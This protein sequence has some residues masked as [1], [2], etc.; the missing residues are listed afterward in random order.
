[1]SGKMTSSSGDIEQGLKE[2][3]DTQVL[4]EAETEPVSET[5]RNSQPEMTGQR[6]TEKGLPETKL[7]SELQTE[8]GVTD[9]GEGRAD[10]SPYVFL[11]VAAGMGIVLLGAAFY[12]LVNQKRKRKRREWKVRK[13]QAQKNERDSIEWQEQDMEPFHTHGLQEIPRTERDEKRPH[14]IYV[15]KVHDIGKRS[16]QQDS[17]GISECSQIDQKGVFAIV[18]DGMGGLANG[19]EISAMVTLSMM[20][21]FDSQTMQ[22][23][24]QQE[25]LQMLNSANDEVN[26]VLGT[27]GKGKSGSTVVAVLVQKD[28]LYWIAVG[29]SHIYL[30]RNGALMQVNREHVYG[31][32][33][34]EQAGRGEISFSAAASDPQRKALTSFIGIGKLKKIDRNIRPLKLLEG[35]RVLLMSDGVFGTLSDGEIAEAMHA[36]AEMSGEILDRMI[37]SKNL[38]NQDNYTA[39]ILEYM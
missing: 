4:S 6:E 26:Q 32:E 3:R 8:T 20:S 7:E 13:E 38:A 15:G 28:E 22:G 34:D 17:F 35:D 1:M 21:R 23:P 27:S 25:L 30:Y 31:V 5:K 24:L 29:D 12:L 19:G 14:G 39:I 36:P 33:L 18:A 10:S 2:N 11:W 37:R 16:S 9:R